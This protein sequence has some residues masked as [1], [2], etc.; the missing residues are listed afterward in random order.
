LTIA[1]D[2]I[3]KNAGTIGTAADSD[4]LTMGNA[5]LT[6]AGEVSMT[7]L[8]IGGTNVT[9]TAAELNLLDGVSGLVQADLTKLAAV[10]S[11]AAELNIVD[12]GTSATSTTI[13]DA[14]RVILNDAGTMKQVAMTDIKTYIAPGSW[15]LLS[16]T[17]A[18]NS[19][20]VDCVLSGSYDNYAIILDGVHPQTDN[21]QLQARVATAATSNDD[22][23][24]YRYIAASSLDDGGSNTYQSQGATFGKVVGDSLGNASGESLEAVIY[25]GNPAWTE[26][27]TRLNIL[28]VHTGNAGRSCTNN[29]CITY[30]PLTAVTKV[31][32]FMSSGNITYGVFKVYGIAG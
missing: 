14:D 22:G 19:G 21:V 29:A 10:D 20:R 8:D 5:I 23:S 25:I 1:D 16:N 15:V 13:V 11:T 24:N 9:S 3:I 27:S 32:F 7:T 4:L 12:G 31:N 30:N 2:L 18:D 6:V 26:H 17:L 28:S